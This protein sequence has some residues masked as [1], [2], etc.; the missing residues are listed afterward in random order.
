ML[1]LQ[2]LR[3]L[4]ENATEFEGKQQFYIRTYSIVLKIYLEK[5]SC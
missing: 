2:Y 1:K 3:I 4:I 5:L